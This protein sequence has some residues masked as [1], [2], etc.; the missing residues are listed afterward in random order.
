MKR[1]RLGDRE[2][3]L[4]AYAQMRGVRT[5]RTG[6]L[7][8]PLGLTATQERGLFS[9]MAR[10][11]LIAK[12][13]RGLYLVPSRL[14]LATRWTPDAALVL[15][16][17]VADTGG[18]YQVCGPNAF[19]LYGFSEQVPQVTCAY[20]NR[21]SGTRTVGVVR[22][23]LIKVADERLGDTEG[24][25]SSEGGSLVYSS[26][27]RTLLDAVYDW[28]RFNTLPRAYGWIRSDLEAGRV[29]PADLVRVTLR[30]G[31]ARTIRRMGALLEGEGAS[32]GLL[33]ELAGGFPPPRTI[34]PFVPFAP[35]AGRTLSRWGVQLNARP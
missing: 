15:N 20:N 8:G 33:D 9:R 1:R 29:A 16:A 30:Y 23:V 13:R 21:L 12:A 4:L 32:R 22:L 19:N 28:P 2:R 27:V 25:G 3:Q 6:D 34:I 14:P 26:R 18:R 11:G 24:R 35:K 10:S 31:N 7:V 5:L 17:L